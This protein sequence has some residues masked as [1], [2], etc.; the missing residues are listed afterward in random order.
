MGWTLT[1]YD[2]DGRPV[3]EQFFNGSGLP[4]PWGGNG[5]TSGAVSTV[6]NAQYTTVTDEVGKARQNQ[7]DG[8][9]RLIGVVED[10]GSSPH[11]NYQTVYGYDALDDLVSVNQSGQTRSFSFDSLKRL[12][13]ATNPESGTVSYKYDSDGNLLTKTDARNVITCFGLL[14]GT[15]CATGYDAL[16][17]LTQKSYSDGTPAVTYSY[18]PNVQF[19]KGR[20]GSI[21]NSNA[22]TNYTSFDAFG[23]VLA[24]N[25]LITGQTYPYA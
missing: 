6:Y 24:S 19:G 21:S 7:V 10:P 17:R 22:T 3:S 9:G 11:L 18:D 20:L 8:L 25:Q 14:S 12:S 16:S 15:S 23:N 4:A 5:N 2:Q 13:S 1:S